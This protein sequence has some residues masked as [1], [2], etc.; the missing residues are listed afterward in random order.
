MVRRNEV[1]VEGTNQEMAAIRT[2]G[3][4]RPSSL[5]CPTLEYGLT[6]LLLRLFLKRMAIIAGQTMPG[7]VHHA[8]E[9]FVGMIE[10][11]CPG[12][13]AELKKYGIFKIT[14]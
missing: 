6:G 10:G 11:L 4:G 12:C 3:Q 8:V 1:S 13:V 14:V 9:R 2:R 5:I 7:K